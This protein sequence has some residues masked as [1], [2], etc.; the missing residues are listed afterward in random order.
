VLLALAAF[1][2]AS[3]HALTAKAKLAPAAPVAPAAGAAALLAVLLGL[4]LLLLL[5]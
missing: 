4:N 1:V 3:G 5:R 2:C